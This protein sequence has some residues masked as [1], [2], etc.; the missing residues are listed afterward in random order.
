MGTLKLYKTIDPNMWGK[1]VGRVNGVNMA[2]LYGGT[3]AM[4]W[5][6]ITKPEHFTWKE[7]MDFLLNT[8]P[9]DVRDHYLEKLE[10]SK[11]SWRVGGAMDPETIAELKAEGAPAIFTGKTNNRGNKD[12][13]VVQF[14]DYLDDTNV[15]DFKRIPT[16]K[17]MCI[18]I[19]KN[20]WYCKYMGF[21]Q[22]KRETEKRRTAMEKYRNL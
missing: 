4:G 20:D 2:G 1:M 3:T 22:T 11:K 13:E 6:N 8:L 21:A 7:Y 19:I 9:D 14:D 18:C 15:T 17:R 5:K 10:A 16:Y 12:K